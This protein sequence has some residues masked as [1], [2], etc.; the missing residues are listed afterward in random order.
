MT[1]ETER[2][3]VERLEQALTRI[4]QGDSRGALWMLVDATGLLAQHYPTAIG[5]EIPTG[6]GFRIVSEAPSGSTVTRIR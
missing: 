2:N 1:R 4:S 6:R 5:V 3:I